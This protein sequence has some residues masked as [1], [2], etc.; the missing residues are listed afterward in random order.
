MTHDSLMEKLI[1]RIAATSER[2]LNGIVILA[3]QS[4]ADTA[5]LG[6]HFKN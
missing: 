4:I 6:I 5:A 3:P 1:L 2:T